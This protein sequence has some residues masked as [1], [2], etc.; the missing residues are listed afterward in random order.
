MTEENNT[1]TTTEQSMANTEIEDANT[2]NP[3][4]ELEALKAKATTLGIRFHP[5]IKS[6]KLQIKIE[7]FMK[8][9]EKEKEREEKRKAKLA[10]KTQ[11]QSQ[12]TSTPIRKA[13]KVSKTEQIRRRATQLIRVRVTCMNPAK[14]EW[15]GEIFNVRNRYTGPVKKYVPFNNEEGWHVPRIIFNYLKT[16]K[17]QIFYSVK[18]KFGNV[19]KKTKNINEFSVE[20]LPPLKPAELKNLAQRQAMASGTQESA[21]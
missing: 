10:E 9:K 6:D 13:P 8:E 5:S 14:K 15:E 18:D 3:D 21:A 20:E 4:Q 16:K 1:E 11:V 2:V 17:C 12:V 19:T 7:D